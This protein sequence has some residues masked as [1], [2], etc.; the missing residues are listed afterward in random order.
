MARCKTPSFRMPGFD[1]LLDG[2]DLRNSFIPDCVLDELKK[3]LAE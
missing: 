2:A 3:T 1:Q